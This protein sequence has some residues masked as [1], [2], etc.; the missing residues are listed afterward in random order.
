[1]MNV[2]DRSVHRTKTVSV[3][4]HLS[5]LSLLSCTSSAFL[6][7]NSNLYFGGITR[8][9]RYNNN[10]KN[11]DNNERRTATTLSQ[12]T[13]I[14]KVTKLFGKKDKRKGGGGGGGKQQPQEK[15]SVKDA[16]FDAMT[17]QFMFTLTG[18]TKVLPDKSK[19]ILNNIYLSFYP[20]A[21]IGVVGLNGSGKSTL[22]KIMAGI[23][24]EYDGLARP[25]PGISIGYLSQE[26]E[27][28]FATVQE[29]V[30]D[31]V[32]SSQRIIDQY[33]DL[34][35]KLADATLSEDEIQKIMS[36]TEELTN[37]IEAGT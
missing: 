31:A 4:Y 30:D 24:T 23:D 10:I 6:I 19:T 22:L 37:T 27:L 25:L 21:K 1:M 17:R 32:K 20:G 15:Q 12:F 8:S 14:P 29:C 2:D 5:V 7:P 36:Q 11:N 28:P 3:L 35:M 33:N 13:F 16:R 34:S 9:I 26:P 18:L